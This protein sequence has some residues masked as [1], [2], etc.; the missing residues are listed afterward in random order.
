MRPTL[1][2]R[3][4]PGIKA[5]M[6][7]L[8]GNIA[9]YVARTPDH[10]AIANGETDVDKRYPPKDAEIG[11]VDIA[12]HAAVAKYVRD[13]DLLPLD[14]AT[15]AYCGMKLPAAPKTKTPSAPKGE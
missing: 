4:V 1:K 2:V 7:N 11:P 5:P 12:V 9:Q 13:G 8:R 3:A 10:A 14:D 15:A 6:P